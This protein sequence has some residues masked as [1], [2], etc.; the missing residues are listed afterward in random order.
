MS[1]K[2]CFFHPE[3]R[4]LREDVVENFFIP[5]LKEAYCYKRAVG[6]F[7]SSALVEISKGLTYIVKKNGRIQIVTSPHLSDEDI[8]AIKKGY[9]KKEDLLEK[10]IL[11]EIENNEITDDYSLQRLNLLTNLIA[12]GILDIKIAFLDNP[13]EKTIGMYHEKLGIIEDE[14]GNKI[15]FSGSINETE[16]ALRT[17]YEVFDV[18]SNWK[19]DD[20]KERFRLKEDAFDRIW[21]D[22]EKGISVF[23]FQS[24]ED[25]LLKK[26][27]KSD[28]DLSIDDKEFSKKSRNPNIPQIPD[29]IELFSYQKK[30][31]ENWEKQNFRGIF[32]MATGT[33]K[34]LTGLGAIT[35]LAK[36]KNGR[37]AVIIVCPF[38][39]LVN[40]WV[41]DIRRF[42]INPI[43]G[44]SQSSQKD[45]EQRLERSIFNQKYLKDKKGFFCFITTNASFSRKKTQEIINKI[46]DTP[47]LLVADEAHN[48][49]S[50]SIIKLLDDRFEY[51]LALSATLDRHMDD[52]GTE[53]LYKF[54][55][56]KCIS[57]PLALAIEEKKLTP[58]KYFPILVSLSDEELR[59]YFE[60]TDKLAQFVKKDSNGKV[61]LTKEGEMIA[62][63][64]ARIVAGASEK[65]ERLKEVIYPYKNEFNIL[66]Y[67]GATNY[68]D[69]E[70]YISD[71]YE[72]SER[73]ISVIVKLLGNDLKMSV[74]KFTADEKSEDR[75]QILER[76][77]A[78]DSLQAL[79][80]IKCLD[81]GVNVPSI[82]TAFILASTTNPKEYIQRRGRV[83]RKFKG[84]EY[85]EIYDFVTLPVALS[86]TPNLTI[87]QL[88]KLQT[89]VK[90]EISRMEEFSKLSLNPIK[91]Q[92]L[93]LDMKKLYH[94]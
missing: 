70:T 20:S 84:K 63:R 92:D 21:N 46:T 44:F 64:R 51:R 49:G 45:W 78:G 14:E 34:T 22:T 37:L 73:Q 8:D 16:N 23:H 28:V 89:L 4:T 77:S 87:E 93:I 55:G 76:F 65:I 6:Y 58:Y 15:A 1:L 52:A 57:Y 68:S 61:F 29:D 7:S 19:D 60:E 13:E 53:Q 12:L 83:L 11:E 90:N 75:K 88:K 38:T 32:D 72:D 31:V 26:Y 42:N 62:L 67:C 85:A 71:E 10:K 48:V 54:F 17:N 25:A 56:E 35:Q 36:V 9:E 50:S 40:Q 33:G 3:Y 2:D 74:S 94:I 30:A 5:L 80:A 91:S 69:G 86:E 47:I 81:E 82:K 41:E 27:K 59:K 39:H 66:V 79:V 43:I 18:Y 24:V